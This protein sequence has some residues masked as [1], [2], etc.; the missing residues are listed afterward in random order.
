VIPVTSYK[1]VIEYGTH[2]ESETE[3][4]A[5][6]EREM[7]EL[8]AVDHFFYLNRAASRTERANYAARQDRLETVRVRLY[9][10]LTSLR[11][12]RR[13][14]RCRVLIRSSVASRQHR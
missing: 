5:R 2:V 6:Y 4:C 10:E 3:L 8:A 14:R 9:S 7:A 13:L 12:L 11:E 1:L